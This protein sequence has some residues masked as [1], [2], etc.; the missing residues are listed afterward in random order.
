MAYYPAT[1][2]V[3]QFFN[4]AGVPLSGGT[5]SAFVHDSTTPTPMYIDDAGTSAGTVITLNA[6][7]EPQVSGNTVAIWLDSAVSYKFVLKDSTATSKW[8]IN[9]IAD[10]GAALREDISNTSNSALGDALI[11]VKQPLTGAG[12]RTQHSKNT[13]Y[14]SVEDFQ[15]GALSDT[16]LFN[17]AAASGAKLIHANGTYNLTSTVHFQ[18]NQVW[19]FKGAVF[20]C[21]DGINVFEAL[22]VDNWSVIG[23]FSLTAAGVG[24]TAKVAFLVEGCRNWL[25]DSYAVSNFIGH[26]FLLKPGVAP[27]NAWNKGLVRNYRATACWTGWED[28]PGTGAEYCRVEGIDVTGSLIVG[29]ITSAGNTVMVG[30]NIVS[31]ADGLHVLAGTNHAHGMMSAVNIN[32]NSALN[33][34]A[35]DVTN[36]MTFTGCHMYANSSNTG[37]GRIYLKNCRGVNFDGGILDCWVYNDTGASNG[38]NFFRNMYCPGDYGDV[39]STSFNSTE[40]DAIFMGCHGNGAYKAGVTI[41]SPASC[42]A[43]VSRVAAATQSVTSNTVLLF[44]TKI[45]DRRNIFST[46]GGGF[47]IPVN[48]AGLYRLIG[49][50]YFF[51]TV[52]DVDDTFVQ[53]RVNSTAKKVYCPSISNTTVLTVNINEELM[54]AASDI[55]DLTATAGGSSSAVTFGGATWRSTLSLERIA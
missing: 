38:L 27:A 55:V 45:M 14:V 1:A 25:V 53:V 43:A 31:N 42:F 5:L 11:G 18:A 16:A 17:A 29:V 30:G 22:E 12:A 44:P 52:V 48:S 23:P 37:D 33:I 24:S 32:H 21:P 13:D 15:T 9:D 36:G 50:L 8:T 51:G 49:S 7:G 28:Q 47:T 6:R 54:L 35:E 46:G 39:N 4:D 40:G 41:N 2:F 10:P 34:F 3:P 20:T 26:G 19:D